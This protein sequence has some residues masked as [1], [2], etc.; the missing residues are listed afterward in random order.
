MTWN[1]T[2]WKYYK[3][4]Y[5]SSLIIKAWFPSLLGRKH[6]FTETGLNMTESKENYDLTLN[7]YNS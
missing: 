5:I 7:N 3:I 1:K 4:I 2:I 6:A